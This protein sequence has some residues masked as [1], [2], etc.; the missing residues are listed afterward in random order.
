MIDGNINPLNTYPGRKGAAGTLQQII[1]QIPKCEVFIDAMC[2]SGIVSSAISGC[3]RIVNDI[4]VSII[5]RLRYAAAD[6]T[7][8]N[9]DYRQV[10]KQY[11]NGSQNRVIYFDVPY[12]MATR[13][14]QL[15][16]YKHDWTDVDHKKFI[17]IARKITIPCMISHYP[18]ALYDNA[19]LK[20]RKVTYQSMTR[21]GIREEALYMNYQQPPLL[22]CYQHIGKNFTD[23]QRIKRKVSR[24]IDKLQKID[25]QERAAILSAI[26]QHFTYVKSTK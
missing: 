15:P 22:Q 4:D 2:G 25:P 18:C 10:L 23:R 13:S 17:A 5:D 6:V 24:H 21:G 14:Y 8:T 7:F 12:L 3:H 9:L 1:S 16:I 19:F 26:I 11:D 20:W